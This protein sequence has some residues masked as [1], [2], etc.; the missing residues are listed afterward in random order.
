MDTRYTISPKNATIFHNVILFVGVTH[1]RIGFKK[2]LVI[3]PAKHP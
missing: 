1:S 2:A 3:F